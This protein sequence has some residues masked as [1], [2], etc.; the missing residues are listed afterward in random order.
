MRLLLT[1]FLALV[2]MPQ[3]V[4]A[5]PSNEQSKQPQA[6]ERNLLRLKAAQQK[7]ATHV[8][9]AIECHEDL[10]HSWIC[11]DGAICRIDEFIKYVKTDPGKTVGML[12]LE[13]S[14]A[15][16]SSKGNLSNNFVIIPRKGFSESHLD[17]WAITP[18]KRGPNRVLVNA[19]GARIPTA[20]WIG[21]DATY[22]IDDQGNVLTH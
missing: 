21:N 19:F 22:K 1:I 17:I 16:E 11:K 13:N 10:D 3:G 20:T 14:S 15:C 8:L 5:N 4:M 7:G 6:S 2:A 12:R 9:S 18:V